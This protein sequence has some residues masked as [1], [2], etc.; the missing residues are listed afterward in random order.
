MDPIGIF[1]LS[2]LGILAGCAVALTI[3]SYQQTRKY[4]QVIASLKEKNLI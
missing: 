4:S 1:F 3:V 2:T